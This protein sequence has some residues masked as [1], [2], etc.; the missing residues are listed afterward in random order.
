MAV[1][2]SCL[3]RNNCGLSSGYTEAVRWHRAAMV[4]VAVSELRNCAGEFENEKVTQGN[5]LLKRK[6]FDTDECFP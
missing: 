5:D 6:A 4:T 3:I 1:L 2:L